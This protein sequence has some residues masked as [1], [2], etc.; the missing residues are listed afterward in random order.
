MQLGTPPPN[1]ATEAEENSPAK[2]QSAILIVA[3]TPKR[4]TN[5]EPTRIIGTHPPVGQFLPVI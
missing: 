3:R 2:A 1:P 5:L 4:P